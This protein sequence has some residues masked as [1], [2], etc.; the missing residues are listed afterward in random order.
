MPDAS[1]DTSPGDTNATAMT[2]PFS[3]ATKVVSRGKNE[4]ER[5]KPA[6]KSWD[7]SPLMATVVP[8]SPHLPYLG[9]ATYSLLIMQ[10]DQRCFVA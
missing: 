1:R 8:Y 6:L 4:F 2:P 10:M 9:E 3:H 5:A 7:M